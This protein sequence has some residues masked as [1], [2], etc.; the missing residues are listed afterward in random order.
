MKSSMLTFVSWIMVLMLIKSGMSFCQKTELESSEKNVLLLE[1]RLDSLN[2]YLSALMNQA[3]LLARKIDLDRE[4]SFQSARK[5]RELEK[6]LQE[7]QILEDQVRESKSRIKEIETEFQES[8]KTVVEIYQKEI[9]RIIQI[10][11]NQDSLENHDFISRIQ[12][13]LKRKHELEMKITSYNQY[14]YSTFAVD[15]R[16]WDTPEELE[17]KGDLYFDREEIFRNE[18]KNVEDRIR[19]LREEQRIRNK[20]AELAGEIELFNER[21][22]VL[23]I[24]IHIESPGRTLGGEEKFYNDDTD[25]AAENLILDMGST[26]LLDQA[27]GENIESAPNSIYGIEGQIKHLEKYRNKI[28]MRADSLHDRAEYFYDLAEKKK[29]QN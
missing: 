26:S 7:S 16:P 20:V 19:S 10:T 13:M 28:R 4:S 23:G 11:E 8:V 15:P 5:H 6:K 17:T 1:S 12:L 21:E 2:I 29:V 25:Y 24:D 18:L 22:E 9:N 14:A 3:K 27:K